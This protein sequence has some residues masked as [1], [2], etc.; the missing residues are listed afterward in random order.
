M[1]GEF[2]KLRADL[3]AVRSA[4]EAEIHEGTTEAEDTLYIDRP[5]LINPIAALIRE[6]DGNW[7][8]LV[9]F[10]YEVKRVSVR[11]EDFVRYEVTR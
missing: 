1:L 3:Q 9:M 4:L 5:K 10:Q 2:R 8:K 6:F 11:V 7:R